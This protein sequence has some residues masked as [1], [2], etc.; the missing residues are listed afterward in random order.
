MSDIGLG[1]VLTQDIEGEEHV[2]AFASRLLRG[3]E[4]SYS[5]SEKECLA[6]VWAVEKWRQY[7]EGRKFE[8]ITDHTALTWA[9][10]HPKPSSRLI[11]W[12]IRLQGFHFTVRYR[13][14]QCNVV[15]DVLSRDFDSTA[16]TLLI[17]T[18]TES[19]SL[20]C[21]LPVDLSQIAMEQNNDPENQELAI[22]SESNL[23]KM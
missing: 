7:L 5:V 1:A 13:K 9:F 22:K 10:Q 23:P 14:G 2:V 15:P 6:V 19:T 18:A 16:D 4:R 11:R 20:P 12:T 3:A 21:N 8:V 17:N